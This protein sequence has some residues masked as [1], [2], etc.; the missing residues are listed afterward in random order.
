LKL[1]AATS[2]DAGRCENAKENPMMSTRLAAVVLAASALGAAAPVQSAKIGVLGTGK[3]IRVN[4]VQLECTGVGEAEQ[5]RAWLRQYTAMIEVVGGY[6]QYLANERITLRNRRG[7]K[8]LEARC[9]APWM[10]LGL[11]PGRYTAVVDLSGVAA[12][13]V[14]F[15]VVD[16]GLRKIVIRFPGKMAGRE[17]DRNRH[18]DARTQ[19]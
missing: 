13:K 12:K 3:P 6:G 10:L 19:S 5:N 4:N 7:A 15:D 18:R 16:S 8:L 2:R 1:V 14:R 11:D 17:I 9:D